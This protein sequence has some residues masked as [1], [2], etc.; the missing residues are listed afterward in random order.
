MF[1][2]NRFTPRRRAALRAADI[3]Q[4]GEASPGFLPPHAINC[5]LRGADMDANSIPLVR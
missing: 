4:G 1:L 2:P 5:D 3:S